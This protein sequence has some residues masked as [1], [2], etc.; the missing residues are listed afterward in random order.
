MTIPEN[1]IFLIKVLICIIKPQKSELA[2]NTRTLMQ[3][4]RMQL[5]LVSGALGELAK[6]GR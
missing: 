2:T 1:F 6:L 4:P 5:P 3:T